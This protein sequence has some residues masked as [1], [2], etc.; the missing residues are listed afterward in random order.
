MP[1]LWFFLTEDGVG[2]YWRILSTRLPPYS[3][4]T[5]WGILYISPAPA[6][7]IHSYRLS[8]MKPHFHHQ[9]DLL[10]CSESAGCAQSEFFNALPNDSNIFPSID[11]HGIQKLRGGDLAQR[12]SESNRGRKLSLGGGAVGRIRQ[13]KMEVRPIEG[14]VKPRAGKYMWHLPCGCCPA[15]GEELVTPSFENPHISTTGLS[16]FGF[17]LPPLCLPTGL[18]A[19]TGERFHCVHLYI[20]FLPHP[21]HRLKG[22]CQGSHPHS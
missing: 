3:G 21:Q 5:V 11:R 20:P 18:W 19:P 12:S 16:Y 9:A 4:H 13:S 2:A 22:K 7:M 6:T 14:S 17:A 15:L 1:K 8:L 10:K